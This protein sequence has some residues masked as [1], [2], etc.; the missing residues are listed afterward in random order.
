VQFADVVPD[1]GLEF[2]EDMNMMRMTPVT[3]IEFGQFLSQGL[4]INVNS[5][6]T[7]YGNS[8]KTIAQYDVIMS[9]YR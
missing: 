4:E 2:A 6:S 9:N 7:R 1:L 8:G 3:M 5:C